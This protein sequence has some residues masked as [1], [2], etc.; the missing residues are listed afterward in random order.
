MLSEGYALFRMMCFCDC[1]KICAWV[2][3]PRWRTKPTFQT[4]IWIKI[5]RFSHTL[6]LVFLPL[7]YYSVKCFLFVWLF[8]I[9]TNNYSK[10]PLNCYIILKVVQTKA[11]KDAPNKFGKNYEY[12]N[13]T[14]HELLNFR[15]SLIFFIHLS[16]RTGKYSDSLIFHLYL[17]NVT[18]NLFFIQPSS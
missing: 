9:G 4:H 10:F 6:R 1:T 14:Y 3:D 7:K 8:Y 11:C 16:K 18:Y 5:N 15:L 13:L 2:F 12:Q 17:C